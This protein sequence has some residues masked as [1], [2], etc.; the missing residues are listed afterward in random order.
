[1][2]KSQPFY[3]WTS[4]LWNMHRH[5][6]LAIMNRIYA[7]LKNTWVTSCRF[8]WLEQSRP[9]TASYR[10]HYH[11]RFLFYCPWNMYRFN[12]LERDQ[13]NSSQGH[14][15]INGP[16]VHCDVIAL[17][18]C[19]WYGRQQLRVSLVLKERKLAADQGQRQL[20]ILV[21]ACRKMKETRASK[22][23][24]EGKIFDEFFSLVGHDKEGK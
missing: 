14:M 18:L 12:D 20:S 19:Q 9:A 3:L 24:E 4:C 10:C 1:M 5:L 22:S 6:K 16:P 15:F 17:G 21:S 8:W 7:Y 23:Q 11:S 2:L 13:W